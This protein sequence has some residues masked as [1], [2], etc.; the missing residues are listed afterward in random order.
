M[1]SAGRN[2]RSL[3]P[4]VLVGVLSALLALGLAVVVLAGPPI[5]RRA[6]PPTAGVGSAPLAGA[7]EAP[8]TSAIPA[9]DPVVPEFVEGSLVTLYQN[10]IPWFLNE[11]KNEKALTLLGKDFAVRPMSALKTGIPSDTRIV[12]IASASLGN[13]LNQIADEVDPAAQANLDAF[14][15]GGGVLVTHLGDNNTGFPTAYRVPGLL[16]TAD[17]LLNC[18]GLS[19]V[20][21]THPLVLGPDGIAGTFDDLDNNKI[22]AQKQPVPSAARDPFA[23]GGPFCFDNHGS[24][25]GI[26]P[27]GSQVVLREEGGKQRPVWAQYPL[28]RGHV[29]VTTLTLEFAP[30]QFQTLVNELHVAQLKLEPKR[31]PRPLGPPISPPVSPQLS[32]PI[33]PPI[34]PP[35]GPPISAPEC[36]PPVSPPISPSLSPPVS[37]PISPPLSPPISPP[38]SPPINPPLSPPISP[39]ISPP[40][41]PPISPQISPPISPPECPPGHT[42]VGFLTGTQGLAATGAAAFVLM[43]GAAAGFMRPVGTGGLRAK[44]EDE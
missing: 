31:A 15:R 33:S 7:D 3:K 30:H 29:I 22:D 43:V 25:A 35:A 14:V 32:P 20:D 44:P 28:G 24:L 16:G 37:P 40:I 19:I 12:I 41:S 13:T 21:S 23:P 9:G 6:D 38:L 11:A 36:P 34:S 26:L 39:Q 2:R 17:D 10:Y 8:D 5:G 1:T 27:A 42:L 18:T 4:L